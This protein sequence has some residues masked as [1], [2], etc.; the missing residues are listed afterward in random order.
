MLKG[1]AASAE[2]SVL[3]FAKITNGLSKLAASLKAG[4]MARHGGHQLAQKSTTT[5]RPVFSI[6]IAKLSDVSSIGEAGNK[7][8]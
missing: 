2:S 5:G 4:S 7:L 1:C 6:K 8:A 3:S